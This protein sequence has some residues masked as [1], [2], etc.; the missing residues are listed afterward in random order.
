MRIYNKGIEAT[1]SQVRCNCCGRDLRIQ[2]G[3]LVEECFHAQN[4]FGYFSNEDGIAEEF[5]LCEECYHEIVADF[6]IPVTRTE[7]T[8]LL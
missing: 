4:V 2:N 6:L 5:D 7:V 3:I 8:E 1:L